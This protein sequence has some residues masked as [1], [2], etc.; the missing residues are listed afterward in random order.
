[1]SRTKAQKA[2]ARRR[3]KKPAGKLEPVDLSA[4]KHPDWMTRSYIN[5]R[6]VVMIDDNANIKGI[7]ATKVMVQRHDDKPVPGHWRQLQN[8]KNELFG[9]ESTAIEFYPPESELTDVANIY[10][11]WVLQMDELEDLSKAKERY[12]T[13]RKLN[14]RQWAEVWRRNI[15]TGKPFDEIIDDY[16]AKRPRGEDDE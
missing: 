13:A 14:P 1:M 3:L 9:Q 4:L 10:W 6:Y 12:E 15:A 5:N 2:E 8:I 7:P 11:L 16:A